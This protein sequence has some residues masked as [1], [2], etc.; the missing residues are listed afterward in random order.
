[1][2]DLQFNDV[3]QLAIDEFLGDEEINSAI[4][5]SHFP[6][7]RMNSFQEDIT[8]QQPKMT[9][10]TT[11]RISNTITKQSMMKPKITIDDIPDELLILISKQM[12]DELIEKCMA[13]I[14]RIKE[15]AK[16][17]IEKIRR[18][19]LSENEIE[20]QKRVKEGFEQL[21]KTELERQVKIKLQEQQEYWNGEFKRQT[22]QWVHMFTQHNQ[23]IDSSRAFL[24]QNFD[25][26]QM[27]PAMGM[28]PQTL[29]MMQQQMDMA[30]NG[31]QTS[32]DSILNQ[33]SSQATSFTEFERQA[34]SPNFNHSDES[35]FEPIIQP[36]QIINQEY[37]KLPQARKEVRFQ[38]TIYQAPANVLRET[39]PNI[40]KIQEPPATLSVTK[41]K[42]QNSVEYY[43]SEDKENIDS[44]T[45]KSVTT[46]KTKKKINNVVTDKSKNP[47]DVFQEIDPQ[48]VKQF[49]HKL[50]RLICG[51]MQS[52]TM[53]L[54]LMNK[55]VY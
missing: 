51:R 26:Q 24:S 21:V 1:M 16:A 38:E 10:N 30:H 42:I 5:S 22:T 6:V 55:R 43:I 39:K 44:Q 41:P 49:H 45:K 13:E 4:N 50:S 25:F 2:F 36:Q 54:S 52:V 18:E 31:Y 9:L 35:Y 20:I 53:N 34:P 47:V 27:V 7:L 28:P 3:G 40:S 11:T 23:N 37:S 17:E 33:R 12:K 48:K 19:M 15:E 46:L 14:T 29:N 8:V 32:T